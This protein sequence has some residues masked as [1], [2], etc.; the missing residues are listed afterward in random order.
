MFR[1][2]EKALPRPKSLIRDAAQLFCLR[3]RST[4]VSHLWRRQ[5]RWRISNMALRSKSRSSVFGLD[6]SDSYRA[7]EGNCSTSGGGSE[8]QRNI[9]RARDQCQDCRNAP[10][11]CYAQAENA[12]GERIG[13]ICRETPHDRA[14]MVALSSCVRLSEIWSASLRLREIYV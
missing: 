12:F 1:A 14:V 2:D 7:R 4:T 10:H 8:L 3:N 9:G 11:Q 13:T 6:L 5:V